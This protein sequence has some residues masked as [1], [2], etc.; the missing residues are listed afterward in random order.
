[1]GAAVPVTADGIPYLAPELQ[2]L[3]KSNELRPKDEVDPAEVMPAL[4]PRQRKPLSHLLEPG[5]PWQQRL[6]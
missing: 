5:H 6:S 1:M 3:Y 2:L 4:E